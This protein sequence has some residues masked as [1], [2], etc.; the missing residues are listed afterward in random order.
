MF[1]HYN[2]G[3]AVQDSWTLRKDC[4]EYQM[5]TNSH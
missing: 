4:S 2:S 3:F 5:N 1:D